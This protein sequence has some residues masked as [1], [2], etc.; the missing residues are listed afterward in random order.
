MGAARSLVGE[1]PA[2]LLDGL[3]EGGRQAFRRQEVV[4]PGLYVP[5]L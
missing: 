5:R 3:R 4:E 1:R 2:D